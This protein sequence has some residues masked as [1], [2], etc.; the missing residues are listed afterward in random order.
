MKTR[1]FINFN[2]ILNALTI[3]YK[4]G[5]NFAKLIFEVSNAMVRKIKK[6][7]NNITPIFIKMKDNEYIINFDKE[8]PLDSWKVL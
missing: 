8:T 2:G 7:I 5:K 6:E 3:L 1:R 4:Y